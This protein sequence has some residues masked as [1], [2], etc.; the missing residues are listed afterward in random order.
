M[1]C[2]DVPAMLT[3]PTSK[4]ANKT[5]FM[6][7]LLVSLLAALLVPATG[8]AA[9][10][11]EEEEQS[12]PQL[13]F[14]PA[15]YDFGMVQVNSGA[16]T[17]LQLRNTGAEQATVNLSLVGPSTESIWIA[18]SD[19]YRTNLQPGQSCYVQVDFSPHDMTEY[20]VQVRASVGFYSFSADV[21]GSGGRAIF[22]PASDSTDFGVAA[23]GSP[24]TTREITVS[25]VG[26][27]PGGVF[28]AVISGGAVGSY[29]LLDEN[30][31]G[32]ELRP[33]ATCTLQVR[34]QPLSEGVKRATLSLFGEQDGGTQ[35]VLTGV[36][37]APVPDPPPAA[38]GPPP[39]A[40]SSFLPKRESP[41]HRPRIRRRHRRVNLD[42]SRMVTPAG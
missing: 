1:V 21:I 18:N 41:K 4:F 22:E 28:I 26:N 5:P 11:P 12:P 10:G 16:Q 9:P 42:I 30:C 39:S 33:A 23:V 13:A 32:R 17:T 6:L 40:A 36:G 20:A 25:N 19:C 34:F 24:G 27:A 3:S 37:T 31:T 35:I 14:E 15:S 8:V 38:S 29:Q 7:A 2:V